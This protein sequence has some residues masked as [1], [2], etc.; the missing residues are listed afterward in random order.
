MI[1]TRLKTFLMLCKIRN[2]RKTA[3]ALHMTQPAVTQH[4]HYVYSI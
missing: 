2:Y 4:I 3:E 1:D